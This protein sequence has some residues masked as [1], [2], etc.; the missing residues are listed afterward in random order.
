[1]NKPLIGV[2]LSIIVISVIGGLLVPYITNVIEDS[3]NDIALANLETIATDTTRVIVDNIT[4]ITI[5]MTTVITAVNEVYNYI[6]TT[7]NAIDYDI[8]RRIMM[9]PI[10]NS[11]FQIFSISYVKRIESAI[12]FQRWVEINSLLYNRTVVI[13]ENNN[14]TAVHLQPTDKT[15]A[16]IS[17][18]VPN[19]A[20]VGVPEPGLWNIYPLNPL[21]MDQMYTL[22]R[23]Q[24]NP[25]VVNSITRLDGSI[26]RTLSIGTALPPD[27]LGFVVFDPVVF[28]DTIVHS[29]T[30]EVLLSVSD[31]NGVFYGSESIQSDLELTHTIEFLFRTWTLH[32]SARPAF[33]KQYDTGSVHIVRIVIIALV[34]LS[35]GVCL[36]VYKLWSMA[37]VQKL[38]EEEL[39]NLRE[40]SILR[41]T[42]YYIM[43]QIRNILNAPYGTLQLA[44]R[45]PPTPD[46]IFS[47]GTSVR[48]CVKLCTNTL[49]FSQLMQGQYKPQYAEMDMLQ[50]MRNCVS[51]FHTA[52]TISCAPDASDLTCLLDTKIIE[53]LFNGYS[54]AVKNCNGKPVD[55]RVSFIPSP[56]TRHMLLIEI[57]NTVP[58]AHTLPDSSQLF[59]PSFVRDNPDT[60][61]MDLSVFQ[62]D[63]E[64]ASTVQP[65]FTK[66]LQVLETHPDKD[67]ESMTT[68]SYGLG[69][70]MA[71]LISKSLGGDAGL[72]RIPNA[73]C[74]RFWFAIR[75][76]AVLAIEAVEIGESI[77]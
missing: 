34:V 8:M 45:I 43:H 16:V 70:A 76:G 15:M 22:I 53:V 29:I 41:Y 42:L 52:C 69:L 24:Y 23:G 77:V 13:F 62:S 46:E 20:R 31:E 64:I 36:M 65:Y 5:D 74:V 10:I 37:Y 33:V 26:L 14:G 47:I 66:T 73:H 25:S 63:P 68:S 72:E 54:N 57:I 60:H 6:N 39:E 59:L 67:I 51:S 27:W 12:D 61:G 21:V 44:D 48:Q 19:G 30:D 4:S 40:Q 3:Q 75:I 2:S 11:P 55:L 50:A 56:Q 28:L 58:R 7:N 71:R 17:A 38:H 1:M 35:A 9:S 32:Y 49:D 18:V